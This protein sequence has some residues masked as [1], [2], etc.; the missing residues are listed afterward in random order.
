MA[1]TPGRPARRQQPRHHRWRRGWQSSATCVGLPRPRPIAPTCCALNGCV[2]A[3][4]RAG[5]RGRDACA[6]ERGSFETAGSADVLRLAAAFFLEG[7]LWLRPVAANNGTATMHARCRCFHVLANRGQAC[8]NWLRHRSISGSHTRVRRIRQRL[9]AA[10]TAGR[11]G[12]R[13]AGSTG[14]Q[15]RRCG[16]RVS[17][18]TSG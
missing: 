1:P 7:G 13:R 9:R 2:R 8:A 16:H 15:R 4:I 11:Y 18:S 17:Y 5:L 14:C 10:A 3:R 12:S 6:P